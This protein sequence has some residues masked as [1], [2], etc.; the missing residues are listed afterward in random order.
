MSKYETPTDAIFN[1]MKDA[2]IK[3]W[4]TYDNQYGYVDEKVDRINSVNNLQD[5]AMVFYRMFDSANQSTMTRY[6]SGDAV[7]YINDNR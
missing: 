5:N 7:S 3:I 2:A 6:M 4:K 1:E